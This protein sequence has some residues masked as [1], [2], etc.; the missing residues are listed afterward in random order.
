MFACTFS[1]ISCSVSYISNILP[2]VTVA[3]IDLLV[4]MCGW[5]M[6]RRKVLS[7]CVWKGDCGSYGKVLWVVDKI[8]KGQY[9][10]SAVQCSPSIYHLL[11]GGLQ[12]SSCNIGF[13]RFYRSINKFY[14][15]SIYFYKRLHRFYFKVPKLYLN[16]CCVWANCVLMH[17]C[18]TN[19]VSVDLV[20]DSL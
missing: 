13:H 6:Y 10:C 9:Q 3:W 16:C 5:C 7:V 4:S 8:R 18:R 11:C 14:L 1:L 20:E 12:W 2:T 19:V 15:T 17:V